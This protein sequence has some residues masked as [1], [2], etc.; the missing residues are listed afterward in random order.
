MRFIAKLASAF[1]RDESGATSIEYAIIA[2]SL[3]IVILV[4][5]TGIGRTLNE[6]FIAMGAAF[7]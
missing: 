4:A 1:L 3:S 5:V 2:G 6:W 7:R